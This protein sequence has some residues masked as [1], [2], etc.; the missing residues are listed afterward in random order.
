MPSDG[1]PPFRRGGGGLT[2]R[3]LLRTTPIS[4]RAEP[5]AVVV[6]DFPEMLQQTRDNTD[7]PR[8]LRKSEARLRLARPPS[9]GATARRTRGVLVVRA[10]PCFSVLVRHR[11]GG[12]G[13]PEW[14]HHLPSPAGRRSLHSD[15]WREG[16]RAGQEAGA[17]HSGAGQ[18]RRDR[19]Q[20]AHW[21]RPVPG[22]PWPLPPMSDA[23]NL[24]V[25]SWSKVSCRSVAIP[26]S[27]YP[28]T[29]RKVHGNP[30]QNGGC[31]EGNSSAME[32]V[33]YL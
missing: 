31:N 5:L 21:P 12:G 8:P 3:R 32:C 16:H 30:I 20:L 7:V 23:W 2:W 10:T 15:P 29:A 1:P 14:S 27:T 26:L 4:E 22:G 9:P 17:G 25:A 11:A 13:A 18:R 28:F 24:T 19:P 33:S 6:E